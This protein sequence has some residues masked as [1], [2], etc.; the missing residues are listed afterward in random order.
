MSA[1]LSRRHMLR[2]AGLALMGSFT[3]AFLLVQQALDGQ[4]TLATASHGGAGNRQAHVA[5][6]H[7]R[8]DPARSANGD[9]EEFY[10]PRNS[11]YVKIK[12]EQPQM[13][14]SRKPE[15]TSNTE[16]SIYETGLEEQDEPDLMLQLEFLHAIKTP[17]FARWLVGNM[18][19]LFID[20]FIFDD[21]L[22]D[23]SADDNQPIKDVE[24][25]GPFGRRIVFHHGSNEF[26]LLLYDRRTVAVYLSKSD[27]IP[28]NVFVCTLPLPEIIVDGEQEVPA[29]G[30]P[31]LQ[32][33]RARRIHSVV[34]VYIE[35]IL[36]GWIA[37][38][39]VFGIYMLWRCYKLDFI[40]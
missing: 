3:I 2:S 16:S 12:K 10:Q 37:L 1:A 20:E 28:D 22:S 7:F 26:S 4:Q 29:D 32:G 15:T 25:G 19:R 17:A 40:I 11:K 5:D 27:G 14:Q 31:P 18:H 34:I 21:G 38:S 13:Q 36:L 9:D 35:C 23:Q 33:R 8:E 30:Q 39:T 24:D 6:G